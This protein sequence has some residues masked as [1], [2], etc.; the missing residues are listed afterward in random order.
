MTNITEMAIYAYQ[1]GPRAA[2]RP[3][4]ESSTMG[5]A[6]SVGLLARERGIIVMEIKQ[7][8]GYTFILNRQ[9]RI[10]FKNKIPLFEKM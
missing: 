8:R 7:G 4:Y 1:S 5:M 3:A 9:F 2:D 10:N 6:F